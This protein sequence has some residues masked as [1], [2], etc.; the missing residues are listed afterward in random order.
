M[1]LLSKYKYYFA[2]F[3]ICIMYSPCLT[4]DGGIT[5]P[6]KKSEKLHRSLGFQAVAAYNNTGYK[7]GKWHDVMWYEK[8]ISPHINCPAP[9]ISI[10]DLPI[11]TL[12]SIIQIQNNW[13]VPNI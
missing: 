5:L 1:S 3:K 4:S 10:K 6:N 2:P 7:C 9:V 12:T 11:E 8:E 13:P